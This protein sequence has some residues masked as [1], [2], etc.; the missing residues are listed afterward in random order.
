MQETSLE[1]VIIDD[2]GVLQSICEQP[3][4]GTI[5]DI[6]ILPRNKLFHTANSQVFIYTSFDF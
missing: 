4:F 3:V 2:Y 5:K 6:A 1:L